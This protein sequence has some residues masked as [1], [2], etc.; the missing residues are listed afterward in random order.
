MFIASPYLLRKAIVFL[1]HYDDSL[2]EI[3]ILSVLT[4]SI[5]I[6]SVLYSTN[7]RMVDYIAVQ[8]SCVCR[9][10]LI[11]NFPLL[12]NRPASKC[13]VLFVISNIRMYFLICFYFNWLI[14]FYNNR[15][16]KNNCSI[17]ILLL[18]ENIYMLTL[19]KNFFPNCPQSHAI[20]STN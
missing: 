18:K 8:N 17:W 13:K 14:T 11:S 4:T 16:I 1:S 20:N 15:T 9:A 7:N 3:N 5:F 12:W 2:L 6:T 19:F 10:K